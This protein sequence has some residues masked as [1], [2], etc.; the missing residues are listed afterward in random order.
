LS[1]HRRR[2]ISSQAFSLLIAGV[3]ASEVSMRGRIQTGADE[4]HFSRD[5]HPEITA[6]NRWEI[7]SIADVHNDFPYTGV[8]SRVWA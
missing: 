1:L 5:K 7:I 8:D 2:V 3:G 6:E 4:R